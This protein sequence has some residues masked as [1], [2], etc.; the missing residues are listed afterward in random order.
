MCQA[1]KRAQVQ[2]RL[3]R[4]VV[5]CDKLS[6]I[7]FEFL[8]KEYEE[9]IMNHAECSCWE[10]KGSK[11]VVTPF[12][13][14]PAEEYVDL[15]PLN[16]FDRVVLYAAISAYEQGYQFLSFKMMLSAMTG[17]DKN[18][19]RSE[20]FEAI[21]AAVKRLMTVITINLKPL[22]KAFP[23]YKKRH[24]GASE[25]ISPILPCKL[26]DVEINGQRT[27]AIELLGESPLMTV[28]KLK[29]QL[30]TYD[31]KPLAVP[32]Q[33]NTPTV[34][35]LKDYLLRRIKLMRSSTRKHGL[36]NKILFQTLYENCG[37][38]DADK[39]QKQDARKVISET[40]NH[41]KAEG[42]IK[43]FEFERQGNTYHAIKIIND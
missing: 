13:L 34:I 4:A 6:D 7:I 20:Q 39:W 2:R 17:E 32:N 33:N 43:N 42:V 12:W 22:L 23:K 5:P 41:F 38:A 1:I 8:P 30:I 21:K 11:E 29:Q 26:C 10:R 37:L 9:I 28:A 16:A 36:S 14:A 25:L 19:V 24:V 18:R 35:V 31:L 15:K 3:I 27:L 40:L